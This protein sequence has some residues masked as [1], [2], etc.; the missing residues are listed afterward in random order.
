M[1]HSSKILAF[2]VLVLLVCMPGVSVLAQSQEQIDS[3]R[4]LAN[5]QEG[6][7]KLKTLEALFKQSTRRNPDDARKV[8]EEIIA[9]GAA[10]NWQSE[11]LLTNFFNAAMS[12]DKKQFDSLD[13]YTLRGIEEARR[14][15]SD[16]FLGHLYALRGVYHEQTRNLDSAIHYYQQPEVRQVD[17]NRMVLNSLGV[18]Y[19]RQQEFSK[20]ISYYEEAL[21]HAQKTGNLV[22]QGK[23]YNN[24]GLAFVNMDRPEKARAYFEKGLMIQNELN[25]TFTQMPA[26]YNLATLD[27]PPPTR[28][29]WVE[30][31]AQLAEKLGNRFGK[32]MFLNARINLLKDEQKYEQALDLALPFYNDSVIVAGNIEGTLLELLSETYLEMGNLEAAEKYA[33]LYKE[34]GQRGR[35]LGVI[36][37]ANRF[38]LD[39]YA[40]RGEADKYFE[41]A[42]SYYPRKDSLDAQKNRNEL[43]YLDAEL[44]DLEQEKAI[45]SLNAELAQRKARRR[46]LMAVA[47]L[48][49]LLLSLI[50]YFRSRQV[51]QQKKLVEQEQKNASVLAAANKELKSL[52][53]M[54]SRFFA[55]ISHEL[56]TPLTL[57][58]APLENS[59][60]HNQE[61]MDESVEKAVR[62][63]H[64][65]A[66]KLGGFVEELLELS[67]LEAGKITLEKSPTLIQVYIN[68]LFAAFES[69]AEIKNITYLLE[70]KLPPESAMLIDKKRFSKIIN[71]LLSNAL[72]FTPAEGRIVLRA[73]LSAKNQLCVSVSDTGRGISKEDLPYIFDRYFQS[74]NKERI[75]E[76]GTGIGLALAKE[77]AGLM[78]GILSVNS[79]IGKGSVFQLK[80]PVEIIAT[81]S[82]SEKTTDETME[83][84]PLPVFAVHKKSEAAS[85]KILIVEDNQDM[86]QMLVELLK[87]NYDYVVAN[88]GAE[89]WQWLQDNDPKVENISL[90]ISD[91]MMPEMDGYT[92]LGKIKEHDSWRQL[93][94]IMLTA[95]AAEEDKLQA[96]RLGVD[97]YLTK[98]FSTEEFFT[99]IENLIERFEE[100][101]S[102]AHLQLQPEKVSTPSADERWLKELEEACNAAIEKQ[103]DITNNY[104]ANHFAM[105]IRQLQRRIKALTGMTSKQYVQEVRLQKA[106]S[107]LENRTYNTIAEVAY[108]SG[109]NTPT[110]FSRVYEKHFGKR[111]ASYFE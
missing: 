90:I 4:E 35:G 55:N 97:D 102:F 72:K 9:L 22:N 100:R 74:N 103:L 37:K 51:R 10:L 3:L 17:H 50:I 79:E 2:F 20:S 70:N 94:V 85:S 40:R 66:N 41:I 23:I 108:A 34:I 6:A 14:I 60:R 19:A 83:V 87:D 106:R 36:Q 59:L 33:L 88:N 49:V 107:L 32:Q 45:T 80:M 82:D 29:K 68:Q 64:K 7:E 76:G 78:N 53:R 96:L 98:P 42:V 12:F 84:L 44:R 21:E 104:L 16:T 95:R 27:I 26:L 110:Y 69:G 38:L 31:G 65:N 67:R 13:Y 86:Q 91:V 52:D 15:E 105:S 56:R 73:E 109:F 47:V 11:P 111:P 81:S 99:R 24:L 61:K 5:R 48:V 89:A 8:A 75:A 93:P 28:R 30:E 39:I 1:K 18:I 101:Q 43:A 92:L 62:T 57:I 71:N 46:W 25:L 77:L 58:T 63:A 54:K